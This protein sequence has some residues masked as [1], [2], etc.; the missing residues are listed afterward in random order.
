MSPLITLVGPVFP[1]TGGI[2]QHNARLAQELE[3]RGSSVVVESWSRQYPGWLHKGTQESNRSEGEVGLPSVIR[4]QLSWHSPLSWWRAG[5]R[6]RS[7]DVVVLTIPTAFHVIPYAVMRLVWGKTAR[8]IGIVHNVTPH[9]PLPGSR[10]LMKF[11]LRLCDHLIVHNDHAAEQVRAL[12]GPHPSVTAVRL[13]S[14][15]S[16]TR[17]AAVRGKKQRK[18]P[19]FLFF[20]TIRPYK[21]LDLLFHA[22]VRVPECSLL[23]AG[24]FW[25]PIERYENLRAELGLESRVELRPG[26]VESDQFEELFTS[27]DTLVL[28]YRSGTGSIVREL[29][30]SYGLPVFATNVGSIAETIINGKNGIVVESESVTA[31]VDGLER[32]CDRSELERLARGV[33]DMRAD[34][35][36]DWERYCQ[37]LLN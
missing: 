14:P 36:A 11:L 15:W 22:L 24:D 34:S 33:S 16:M 30:F 23:V 9:E 26:Y 3:Q 12:S 19:R 28:P 35:S 32:L 4:R 21:G 5:W 17:A 1:L 10:I 31:L 20:G 18:T 2:A 13:P 25:E 29:A 37:A 7:S 27:C 6:S 8:V